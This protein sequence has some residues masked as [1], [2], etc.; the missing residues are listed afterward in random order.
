MGNE[1]YI[2]SGPVE[3]SLGLGRNPLIFLGDL[4]T[5]RGHFDINW[6]LRCCLMNDETASPTLSIARRKELSLAWI[7]SKTSLLFSSLTLSSG[8]VV[9]LGCLKVKENVFY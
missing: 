6:P 8:S 5:P 9:V 7:S 1:V 2:L 3:T 4:K